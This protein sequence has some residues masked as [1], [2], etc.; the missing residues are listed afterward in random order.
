M[1]LCREISIL[2][3][4]V[5]NMTVIWHS[6]GLADSNDVIT[7]AERSACWHMTEDV[8]TFRRPWKPEDVSKFEFLAF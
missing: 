3:N 8:M 4:I 5:L 7:S 1:C 2:K 6:C